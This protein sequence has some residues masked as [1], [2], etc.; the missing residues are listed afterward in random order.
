MGRGAIL[1]HNFCKDNAV[2][3][4]ILLAYFLAMLF[5]E[6]LRHHDFDQAHLDDQEAMSAG[7]LLLLG[8]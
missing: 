2:L 6:I 8:W 4:N 5:S 3:H 7:A 1:M